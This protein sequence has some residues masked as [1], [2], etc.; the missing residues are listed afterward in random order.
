[1]ARSASDRKAQEWQQRFVRFD[2]SRHT[3][4]EFCGQEGISPQSFYLW[5][6]RLASLPGA[7]RPAA[8]SRDVFRPVHVL[9]TAGVSVQLPGGTQLVVP[10]ADAESLRVVIETLARVDADRLGGVRPC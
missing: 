10:T 7:K 5:R 8:P 6:K 4:N 1:M 2:K 9:P 3:I